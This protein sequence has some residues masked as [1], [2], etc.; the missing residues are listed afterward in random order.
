MT[1]LPFPSAPEFS[2]RSFLAAASASVLATL[3]GTAL[4]ITAGQASALVERALTDINS[5]LSSGK[6]GEAL[7]RE[8]ENIFIRYADVP[9]IA[10]SVLGPDWRTATDAQRRAFTAAFQGYLARKYGKEFRDMGGADLRIER[11]VPVNRYIEVRTRE[12]SGSSGSEV[13]FLVA[14]RSGQARFFDLLIDGVSIRL[15]ERGEI[16]ALLDARRG[17]IDRLIADLGTL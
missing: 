6:S 15:R 5:V 17:N 8:F 4:A 16:G 3:P 11:S 14:D 7:Y 13:T 1:R 2:R 12:S 9:V 10:S